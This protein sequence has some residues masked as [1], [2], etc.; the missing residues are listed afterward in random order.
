VTGKASL[1]ETGKLMKKKANLVYRHDQEGQPYW[2]R[3]KGGKT[4]LLYR[5]D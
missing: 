4:N 1:A 3:Q 2:Q 5:P